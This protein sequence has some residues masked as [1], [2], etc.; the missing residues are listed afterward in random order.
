MLMIHAGIA[1]CDEQLFDMHWQKVV[2]YGYIYE[3]VRLY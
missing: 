1:E 2:V 3:V